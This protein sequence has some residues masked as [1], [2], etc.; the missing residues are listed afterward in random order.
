MLMEYA[1]PKVVGT[2]LHGALENRPVLEE[3]DRDVCCPPLP[4]N[5]RIPNMI[6]SPSGSG[7][8]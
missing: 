5:R 2:Y 4:L 6:V 7:P 1:A 3:V 8:T